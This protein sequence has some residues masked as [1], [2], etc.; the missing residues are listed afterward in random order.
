MMYI[1]ESDNKHDKGSRLVIFCKSA[2]RAIMIA[3][4]KYAEYGFSGSPK[5]IAV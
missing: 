4:V 2:K 3:V 5:L 1:F